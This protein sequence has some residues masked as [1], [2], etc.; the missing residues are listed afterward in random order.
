[1][2]LVCQLLCPP[3]GLPF[4]LLIKGVLEVYRTARERRG[5]MDYLGERSRELRDRREKDECEE[6][7]G[8][9]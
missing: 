8:K 9:K 7:S 4:A 1:M 3:L 6:V 5:N 2:L